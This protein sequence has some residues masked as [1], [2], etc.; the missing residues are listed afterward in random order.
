MLLSQDEKMRASKFRFIKD[1]NL[2]I[3]ARGALRVLSS[4]YLNIPIEDVSFLYGEFGKPEYSFKSDLKFNVSHSGDRAVIGFVKHYD[5]GVDIEKI[6]S[7]FDVLDIAMNY[8]SQKEISELKSLPK[9]KHVEGFY[10]CWTRKESFIKAKSKGLSFPLD[11]FSVS[12]NSKKAVRLLET[13]WNKNETT[14][15]SLFS[16]SPEKKYI[17]AVSIKAQTCNIEYHDF[18]QF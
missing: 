18:D 11:Q 14:L 13:Q 8:F 3:L 1:K 10:K 4:Y 17:G 15:W 9:H 12:I 5:I 7:N 2:F 16:F 6:K